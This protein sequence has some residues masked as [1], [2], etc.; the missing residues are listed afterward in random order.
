[1]LA[2]ADKDVKLEFD[3]RRRHPTLQKGGA[4]ADE[5]DKAEA[6]GGGERLYFDLSNAD[7][8]PRLL[9]STEKSQ[10]NKGETKDLIYDYRL[11]RK[12][13]DWSTGITAVLAVWLALIFMM[14]LVRES[15]E[16]P[17]LWYL[18]RALALLP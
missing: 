11:M 8:I 7:L 10:T 12:L 1:V 5:A 6:K 16:L 2:A 4:G 17:P 15:T 13:Q 18:W 9:N 14:Q 3:M